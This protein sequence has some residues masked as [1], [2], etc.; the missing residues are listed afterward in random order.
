MGNMIH[1]GIT[2]WERQRLKEWK[3]R[4]FLS[5]KQEAILQEIEKKAGL[6]EGEE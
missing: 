6:R 5:E 4:E 2:D 3:S 1:F